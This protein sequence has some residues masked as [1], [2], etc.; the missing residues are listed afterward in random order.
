MRFGIGQHGG[1][2]GSNDG[3]S[4][5]EPFMPVANLR[6][7]GGTTAPVDVASRNISITSG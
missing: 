5:Q 1:E 7:W 6:P 4:V 2:T 3:F